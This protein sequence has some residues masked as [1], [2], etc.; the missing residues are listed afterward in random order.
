VDYWTLAAFLKTI[1]ERSG[2]MPRISKTLKNRK[3]EN[4]ASHFDKPSEVVKDGQLSHRQ[5]KEALRTWEQDTR[6]IATANNEG[7]AARDEGGTGS[8]SKLADVVQA[9]DK[10]S[11]KP[12]HKRSH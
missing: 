5:K 10:M 1:M 8:D 3:P 4:P 12:K 11:E 6:Q 2:I 7:M 9:K